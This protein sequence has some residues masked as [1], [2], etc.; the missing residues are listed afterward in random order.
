MEVGKDPPLTRSSS[1]RLTSPLTVRSDLRKCS[2]AARLRRGNDLGQRSK[3][4]A[5]RCPLGR[6]EPQTRGVGQVSPLAR[7]RAGAKVM[8]DHDPGRP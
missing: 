3:Q 6:R 4:G 7:S 8:P 2:F 1:E 5:Y